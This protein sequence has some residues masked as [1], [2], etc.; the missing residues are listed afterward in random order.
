M[1]L[2][3]LFRPIRKAPAPLSAS[4]ESTDHHEANIRKS[5]IPLKRAIAVLPYANLEYFSKTLA[6][7]Y[8]QSIAGK[9]IQHYYDVYIFQDALQARHEN[10]SRASYDKLKELALNTVGSQFYHQQTSNQGTAFQ[11]DFAE[12]YL[13]QE[14]QY[15]FVIPLEHDFVMATNYLD[16]LTKLADHFREDERV[17]SISVHSQ[18]SHHLSQEQQ[19]ARKHE[20]VLMDHDWGAGIFK[21]SW[22]K[23][24]PILEAYYAL[25]AGRTFEERNGL[26]IQEWQKSLGFK[27]G[28]TSQDFIKRCAITALKQIAIT[29]CI[30]LG[31]YIGAQGMNWNQKLYEGSGYHR[32]ITYTGNFEKAPNLSKEAYEKLLTE[33]CESCLE[34]GVAFDFSAF[35]QRVARQELTLDISVRAQLM[36][37]TSSDVVSAYRLFLNRFPEN[38]ATIQGWIGAPLEQIFSSLVLS[39]EFLNRSELWPTLI[40]AAQTALEKN[41]AKQTRPATSYEEGS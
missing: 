26:L 27:V 3:N 33:Q 25:F 19:E 8:K 37:V 2:F 10:A 18:Q 29:P 4:D 32:S 30:N 13:F 6:G 41:K 40:K 11:F 20:Y 39:D 23:R 22:E 1:N 5:V 16:V 36:G 35:A 9:P 12:K 15:D 38:E 28:S 7:I 24:Q 14:K 17:A 34:K 21:R 31:T